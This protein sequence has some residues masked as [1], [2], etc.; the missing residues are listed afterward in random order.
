MVSVRKYRYDNQSLKS[1]YMIRV[2]YVWQSKIKLLSKMLCPQGRPGSLCSVSGSKR[3][4]EA[5]RGPAILG[6]FSR[7]DSPRVSVNL[8][9]DFFGGDIKVHFLKEANGRLEKTNSQVKF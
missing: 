4:E 3:Q 5:S 6:V 2:L 1:P 9:M 7:P 8:V